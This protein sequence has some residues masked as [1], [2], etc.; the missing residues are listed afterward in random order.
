MTKTI[1]LPYTAAT[2]LLVVTYRANRLARMVLDE[3][4]AEPLQ[5]HRRH[6]ELVHD[7]ISV[8]LRVDAPDPIEPG[9]L[10]EMRK[11]LQQHAPPVEQQ[12]GATQMMVIEVP[13]LHSPEIVEQIFGHQVLEE[14]QLGRGEW[15]CFV[16]T[17][18]SLVLLCTHASASQLMELMLGRFRVFKCLDDKIQQQFRHYLQT[19][20]EPL[21]QKAAHLE[22]CLQQWEERCSLIRRSSTAPKSVQVCHQSIIEAEEVHQ[23]YNAT[24][25]AESP[26]A[27]IQAM[28]HVNLKN[29]ETIARAIPPSEASGVV[30]NRLPDLLR[31]RIKAV[32]MPLAQIEADLQLVEPILSAAQSVGTTAHAALLSE[33]TATEAEENHARSRENSRR[34]THNFLLMLA[35]LWIGFSQLWLSWI[36]LNPAD[37]RPT[38][39][40]LLLAVA[41]PTLLFFAAWVAWA[42]LRRLPPHFVPRKAR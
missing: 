40:W 42:G 9:T 11:Q 16:D 25:L 38:G 19:H 37:A 41:A 39:L 1:P 14:C 20:R 8:F 28:L 24:L 17:D 35:A 32:E 13:D 10:T 2:T 5:G 33:L 29:L 15:R 21:L 22:Q 23:A 4:T 27:Q 30:S 34:E 18:N 12:I 31:R 3:W 36:T 6:V 7:A 26:V